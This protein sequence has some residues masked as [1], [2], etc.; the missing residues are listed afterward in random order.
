MSGADWRTTALA[1][2]AA[3]TVAGAAWKY[4]LWPFCAAIWAAIKAAPRIAED[5]ADLPQLIADLRELLDANVVGEI[6]NLKA[7]VAELKSEVLALKSPPI[8]GGEGE[9]EE[10]FMLTD[11]DALRR[12]QE[13]LR[14]G[15]SIPHPPSMPPF[16]SEEI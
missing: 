16:P 1:A 15:S 8:T 12:V 2:A 7:A 9:P 13:R 6:A 3:I 14:F 5:V 11:A 4:L 10:P